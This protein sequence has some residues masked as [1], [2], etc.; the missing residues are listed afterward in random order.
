[1]LE[2]FGEVGANYFST[3][4]IANTVCENLKTIKAIVENQCEKHKKN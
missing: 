1:M 3:T 2:S 4:E